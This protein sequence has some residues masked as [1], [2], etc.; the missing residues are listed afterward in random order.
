MAD[1]LY[2]EHTAVCGD[3][4]DASPFLTLHEERRKS[5]DPEDTMDPYIPAV[6]TQYTAMEDNL[7]DRSD[8]KQYESKEADISAIAREC[9]ISPLLAQALTHRGVH[10][11]RQAQLFLH[12]GPND[13]EDPHRLHHMDETARL[14]RRKI[15]EG[16]KICVIGDY[17]VDGICSSYILGTVLSAMHAKVNIAIPERLT[18][19]Y[20]INMRLV[21]LAAD[22]GFD[23]IITCDNGISAFEPLAAAKAK[24]MTVI[25]TDHHEITRTRVQEPDGSEH[26]KSVI[27]DCDLMVNPKEINPDTGQT[28]CDYYNICGALVVF[29]LAQVLLDAPVGADSPQGR[30]LDALTPFAALAT[31]SDVM[32]LTGD[33]RLIARYGLARAQETSNVGLRALL[34]RLHLTGK[35][36]NGYY[37][38]FRIGPAINAAGRM[39]SPTMAL[40]LLFDRDERKAMEDADRIVRLNEE[41]KNATDRGNRAAVRYVEEHH[42]ENCRILVLP[43]AECSQSVAGIVAGRMRERYRRPVF[44]LTK[45]ADGEWK[46]SGRSVDAYNLYEGMA[47][48]RDL[49]IQFGGHKGAGGL[50]IAEEQIHAF[51]EKIN[52]DCAL[53][54]EDMKEF[55]YYDA[56]VDPLDFT[57]EQVMSFGCMEPCG[58]GNEQMLFLTEDLPLRIRCVNPRGSYDILTLETDR[59]REDEPR[60]FTYFSSGNEPSGFSR[61][62]YRRCWVVYSAAYHTYGAGKIDFRIEDYG[63]LE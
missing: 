43:L 6:Q 24:G 22:N 37:A 63:F 59:S 38:G 40:S 17:D 11:G 14:L 42:K 34:A 3:A 30:L 35:P 49:L 13:M 55:R 50:S 12:G 25:I 31:I 10:D 5:E 39:A 16:R 44:I 18:D 53:T 61:D 54:L 7:S 4:Q 1:A 41:R 47:G 56:V 57:K 20:G 9:G 26:M 27:P 15:Q 33:N 58:N 46:G 28:Y 36:L 51:E 32:P 2:T 52:E 21:N 62:G 8:W 48:C 23:T 60:Q 19:G 29:K 45:A